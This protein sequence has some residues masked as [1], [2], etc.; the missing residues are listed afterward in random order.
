MLRTIVWVTRRSVRQTL[1]ASRAM[2][3]RTARTIRARL[4]VRPHDGPPDAEAL[5]TRVLDILAA[6]HDGIGVREIGNELGIDWRRLAPVMSGLVAHGLVDQI[7]QD[8]YLTVKA[9]RKC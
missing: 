2:R 7:E 4:A 3:R 5:D 1:A 6:H 8:F 9:S